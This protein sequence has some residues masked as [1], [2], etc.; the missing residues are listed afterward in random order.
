MA[1]G[2]VHEACGR[3]RFLL[4]SLSSAV[5]QK[6]MECLRAQSTLFFRQEKSLQD[7]RRLAPLLAVI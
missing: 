2:N 3:R 1:G 6:I 7:L 5:G 4:L